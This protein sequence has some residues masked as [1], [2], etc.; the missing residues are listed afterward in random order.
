MQTAVK[1]LGDFT[2]LAGNYARFRQGYSDSV[3][4]AILAMIGKPVTTVDAADLG[5]G[6]GIWTRMIAARGPHSIVAVEPNADMRSQGEADR[7][8]PA[9]R[10]VGAGGENTGL[11]AASC[12]LVTAASSFHWMDYPVVSKEI[13]RILRPG[14]RFAALWNP[15]MTEASPLLAEIEGHLKV[16]APTLK[17]VSSGRSDFTES[18][19]ERLTTTP[20]F[21]DFVY[22]EGRHIVSQSPDEYMGAWHSVN[23]IQ[24]QLGP[25]GWQ[26]FLAFVEKKI[27][28]LATIETVFL[29]R[30]WTVRHTP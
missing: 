30:A 6:T 24:A 9:V 23:D 11:P 13:K 28:G 5:A 27:A 4:T 22:L 18:L 2:G 3:L 19:A 25:D 1:K 26:K 7:S 10:W 17:R 29:T 12:D 15:R 14:G 21:D 20:G 16:L 8:Q